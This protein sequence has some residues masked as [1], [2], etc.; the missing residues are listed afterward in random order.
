VL[1]PTI[2]VPP[3]QVTVPAPIVNVQVPERGFWLTWLPVLVPILSAA[4]AVISA[5]AAAISVGLARRTQKVGFAK[6]AAAVAREMRNQQSAAALLAF[7]NNVARPVGMA[8][9]LVERM[10]LELSRLRP[11]PASEPP[12]DP[13]PTGWSP[14]RSRERLRL[15]APGPSPREAALEQYGAG[16]IADNSQGVRLCREADGALE[17]SRQ[18]VFT[19]IFVAAHLDDQLLATADQALSPTRS[20]LSDDAYDTTWQAIVR[21][22]VDMRRVLEAERAAEAARWQGTLD[23]DPFFVEVQRWL[24]RS[25]RS[26]PLSEG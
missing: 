9:D 19:D 22:K 20:V 4:A 17:A 10:T 2:N 24:P 13:A 14:W 16:V 15:P 6:D 1:S 26:R 5:T 18:P 8:L 7:E 21:L 25:L 3:A 12:P 11:V 23:A